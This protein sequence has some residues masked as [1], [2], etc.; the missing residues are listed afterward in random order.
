MKAW[1][2]HNYVFENEKDLPGVSAYLLTPAVLTENTTK[3]NVRVV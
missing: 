2:S 3:A 1:G